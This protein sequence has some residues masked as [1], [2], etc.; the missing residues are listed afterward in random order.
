MRIRISVIVLLLSLPLLSVMADKLP[1]AVSESRKGVVSIITYKGGELKGSG[2]GVFA[3]D[4]A[5]LLS[6]YSLFLNV[7]SAIAIDPSGKVRNITHVAGAN[8]L[9][10]CIKLRVDR[11]KK[12]SSLPI[13]NVGSKPGESLFVVSYGAKKSGSIE[14]MAVSA[15]D[16]MSGHFYYTF[17]SAVRSNNISAPV[18]NG[19]GELVALIQPAAGGD[20]INSYAIAA[21]LVAD[22]NISSVNYNSDLFRNIAIRRALP[23]VQSEALTCVHLSKI[24]NDADY[25]GILED[26]I[27][28]FPDSY[29]GY[30][31]LAER[32][33]LSDG[34]SDESDKIWQQ[35]LALSSKPDDVYYNKAN[36][37]LNSVATT[38]SDSSQINALL[39]KALE[40]Y[41]NA[42]AVSPEPLYILHK[43]DLLYNMGDY[44]SAFDCYTSIYK[45]NMCDADLILKASVCKERLGEYDSALAQ[46]DSLPLLCGEEY[47]ST[48]LLLKA[49]AEIRMGRYRNA[50]VSYNR[51]E[52][53]SDGSLSAKFYFMREQ[54]EY[55]AKMFQQAL[56]DIETA[57]YMQPDNITY[58]MEKAR[59][60]YR[61]NLIDEALRVLEEV[62]SMSPENADVF[63]LKGRCYMVKG[64]NQ[65]ATEYLL[66]AKEYGHPD[67]HNA[68]EKLN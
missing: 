55:K 62:E 29:E 2:L 36:A 60:C 61:V 11:D 46:F 19:K 37:L 53:L 16:S 30:M 20:T 33:M 47:I 10:D 18:V 24:V 14:Q 27:S 7:D 45:T 44:S 42:I 4:A 49:E 8:E 56:N 1:K 5:E 51:I 68:L 57:I 17:N 32:K 34:D 22:L 23:D 54:A 21:S 43:G 52:E 66:K 3:G 50:V 13:A 12:I 31:L 9:Y 40:S 38:E 67:A 39:N 63:Y 35:A 28:A 64:D 25:P 48:S 41:D 65:T 26:Y 58:L 6:S 59:I 15:V